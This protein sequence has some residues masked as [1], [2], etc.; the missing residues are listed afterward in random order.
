M[1]NDNDCRRWV[2]DTPRNNKKRA[3]T[4]FPKGKRLTVQ[5]AYPIIVK[6]LLEG[7]G[8][9][10][11]AKH[12]WYAETLSIDCNIHV[13]IVRQVFHKLNLEGCCSKRKIWNSRIFPMHTRYDYGDQVVLW[14]A[15]QYYI[16]IE[17]LKEK[18]DN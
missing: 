11:T 6:A 17:K 12:I 15:K 1:R 9:H 18:Y 10:P 2:F 5:K 8:L 16:D 14:E 13:D 3:K 4:Y 7:K